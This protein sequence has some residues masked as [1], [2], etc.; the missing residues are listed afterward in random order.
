M[1]LLIIS[2]LFIFFGYKIYL[3]FNLLDKPK[4]YGFKRNPVP[5]SFGL[6]L[7]FLFL[8]LCYFYGVDILNLSFLF[9]AS[10]VVVLIAFLDDFLKISPIIRLFAQII[11]SCFVVY[12]GVQISEITNP[13]SFEIISLKNLS[14]FIS[15]IWIVFLTNVMNFLDG[16]EGLSSGVSSVGF[17]TIGIL[18]LAPNFHLIDQSNLIVMSFLMSAIS[19][20]AFI[21]EFPKP[22]PKLLVGDSGTMF[23]GFLLACFSMVS[24]GKLFTLLIVLL[25]PIMDALFVIFHRIFNKKLPFIGDRNHFHHKLLE[26]NFSRSSITLIYF[27]V[28]ILLGLVSIFAWNTYLKLLSFLIISIGFSYLIWHVWNKSKV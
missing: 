1:W 27:L 12:N 4:N 17:F 10:F 25:I 2:F 6:V 7:Y 11:L 5:Y 9:L 28:S 23:Y 3:H 19:F 20:L 18:S 24:G 22:F 13:F 16:V 14:F 21:F 26:L 8:L 15:V